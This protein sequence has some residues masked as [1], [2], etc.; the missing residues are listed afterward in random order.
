M[1]PI[2][3][4]RELTE[5]RGSCCI[6]G[7]MAPATV[8]AF[9]TSTVGV[10]G[11][12]LT[13]SGHAELGQWRALV[14]FATRG[15]ELAELAGSKGAGIGLAHA[16]DARSLGAGT[17]WARAARALEQELGRVWTDIAELREQ[18]IALEGA[19]RTLAR[20]LDAR[21]EHLV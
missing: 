21:T 6:G 18:H 11:C 10:T 14:Q 16:S 19:Y 4:S 13:C 3:T 1:Q 9:A 17:A 15:L 2:L 12:A 20:T 8:E 7:C 5:P